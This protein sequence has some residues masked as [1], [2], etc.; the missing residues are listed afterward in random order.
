MFENSTK[1]QKKVYTVPEEIDRRIAVLK[2][3][4][5]GI[6]IDTLTKQ[7]ED[8]LNAWELGT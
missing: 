1:L 8:Y 2:L 5:M 6:K 3:A 4:S 7:Q